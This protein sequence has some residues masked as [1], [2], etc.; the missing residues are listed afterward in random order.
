MNDA[1]QCVA[2]RFT[3]SETE[4]AKQFPVAAQLPVAPAE[5]EP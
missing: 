5:M 4:K 2:G 1:S 3:G